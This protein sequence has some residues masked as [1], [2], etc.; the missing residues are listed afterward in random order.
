MEVVFFIHWSCFVLILRGG[1]VWRILWKICVARWKLW[2]E[3]EITFSSQLVSVGMML[4]IMNERWEIICLLSSHC[5]HIPEQCYSLI[6]LH[7]SWSGG[8]QMQMIVVTRS[9]HIQHWLH[10]KTSENASLKVSWIL[11]QWLSGA[12]GREVSL[13]QS[14]CDSQ[15]RMIYSGL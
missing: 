12:G 14:I 4:L 5:C 6:L 11:R 10:H 1:K 13:T 2:S 8:E 3:A 9:L 15:S 7:D